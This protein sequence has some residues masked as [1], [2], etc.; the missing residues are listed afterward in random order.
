M[1]TTIL[2]WCVLFVSCGLAA[3][4]SGSDPPPPD[5]KAAMAWPAGLPVYDHVVIEEN[6][7]YEQI[8]DN[9]KAPYLNLTLRKEGANLTR[10]F[11]EEHNSQGNYFWL[12]S[13]SNQ[14]VGFRNVIPTKENHKNYPFTAP[15]LGAALI[16]K[17]LSFKGY[18]EDLP[19]IG[20]RAEFGK[21][22][23][24]YKNYAR[25]HN[26]WVSFKYVPNDHPA[27]SSNLRFVDFPTD[28]AKFHTLPTVA[29]V[30]PGLKHDMH[31]GKP[32]ESIPRGDFWLKRNLDAYYQWAKTH[33]SL[34]IVT[35]DEND[36]QER[37]PRTGAIVHYLGLT[38]P[39]VEPTNQR[40][41]NIQNRIPT[42][43]AG[44][45]VK[46]GDFPE[47]K[48][49]T[50]VNLLRT[51]EAMYGLPRAGAQQPKAAAG[52]IRDD[53]IITDVFIQAK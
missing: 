5:T 52:G 14:N 17:G 13:G 2:R 22:E 12:F 16:K 36:D 3:S 24:G 11:A 21:D 23:D 38:D 43:L 45:R 4:W 30:V 27:T 32:T 29:I 33:N 28:P 40:K 44:A 9:P 15:N 37:D 48:G 50:H 19:A 41:R 35:W 42:I 8:I 49:V 39:F 51:L 25:K 6:Q 46:H 53:Y 10:M 20:S 7:D 31:D 26:P 34:L 18:S 47:G 1:K